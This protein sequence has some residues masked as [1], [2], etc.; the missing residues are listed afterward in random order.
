M[1]TGTLRSQKMPS[2]ERERESLESKSR[3][4]LWNL[5]QPSVFLWFSLVFWCLLYD[6]DGTQYLS[7]EELF[8]LDFGHPAATYQLPQGFWCGF[9]AS[10]HPGIYGSS[11][12]DPA[13]ASGS[14]RE[15]KNTHVW[16]HVLMAKVWMKVGSH[17][18]WFPGATSSKGVQSG[19]KGGR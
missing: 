12:I 11:E 13:N 19:Y 10:S 1:L 4:L 7:T 5:P 8:G 18:C 2:L 9:G 17:G 14:A 16:L 15:H 3:E 6:T